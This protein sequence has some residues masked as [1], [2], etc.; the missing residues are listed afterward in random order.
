MNRG[1]FLYI[2][3]NL[4]TKIIKSKLVQRYSAI[5]LS[6]IPQN[7]INMK[8]CRFL[9]IFAKFQSKIPENQQ[10]ITNSST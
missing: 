7:A 4:H 10:G 3:A 5:L 6:S 8:R 2:L 9:N 1:S